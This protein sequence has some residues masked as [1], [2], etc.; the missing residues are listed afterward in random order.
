VYKL[1]DDSH[2][3]CI[4]KQDF[5]SEDTLKGNELSLVV[6]QSQRE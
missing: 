3:E 2:Q 1:H 4:H 6:G 5:N